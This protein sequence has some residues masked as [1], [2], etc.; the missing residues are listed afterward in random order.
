M[1]EWLERHGYCTEG[2]GFESRLGQ[3]VPGKL[4]VNSAVNGYTFSHSLQ[5]QI[6]VNFSEF[7][8]LFS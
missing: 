4:S 7:N 5:V 2:H 3:L 6:L 1:V 8:Y